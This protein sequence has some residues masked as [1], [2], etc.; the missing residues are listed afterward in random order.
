MSTGP[1]Q[2]FENT[3][4]QEWAVDQTHSAKHESLNDLVL[5]KNE[6]PQP[7]GLSAVFCSLYN[8]LYEKANIMCVASY[9][10]T[11]ACQFSACFAE[12]PLIPCVA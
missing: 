1:V 11:T 7:P 12:R 10:R 2:K 3:R 6:Y 8:K 5:L 4:W 9:R